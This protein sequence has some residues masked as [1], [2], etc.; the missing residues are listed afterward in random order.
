MK[1]LLAAVLLVASTAQH[2]PEPAIVDAV[3]VDAIKLRV[4]SILPPCTPEHEGEL[5][6]VKPETAIVTSFCRCNGQQWK[7]SDAG[8]ACPVGR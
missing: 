1:T 4:Y 7:P 5:R 6:A 2:I 8:E 3:K